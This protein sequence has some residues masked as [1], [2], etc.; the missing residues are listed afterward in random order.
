VKVLVIDDDPMVRRTIER[1]LLFGSHQVLTASD[2]ARGLALFRLAK[3]DVIVT[4]LIM[5]EQEGLG[6]IMMM[7]RERPGARVIA[8]S[9]GGRV[10]NVDLLE[11]A[12]AVGAADVVPKPFDPEALLERINR[13][14]ADDVNQGEIS[15]ADPGAAL[16]SLAQQS[17]RASRSNR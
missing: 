12:K 16:Q 7:R 17:R 4:D 6:T 1:T 2:G 11:A 9:G 10:G 13:L 3:P 5:P 14:A 8:V 15:K